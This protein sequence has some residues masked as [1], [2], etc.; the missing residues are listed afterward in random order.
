MFWT[1]KRGCVTQ[2]ARVGTNHTQ[3][4]SVSALPFPCLLSP[5]L[6]LT[7]R[8]GSP[9]LGEPCWDTTA[10]GTEYPPLVRQGP[11]EPC[12]WDARTLSVGTRP[13]LGRT[14]PLGH[15]DPGRGHPALDDVLSCPRHRPSSA[16][17]RDGWMTRIRVV[18]RVWSSE[19]LR[20][21]SGG[22][23]RM[24]RVV[25]NVA[26]VWATIRVRS[27][28]GD[29]FGVRVHSERHRW[30]LTNCQPSAPCSRPHRPPWVP[31]PW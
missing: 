10:L 19:G 29:G 5:P 16:P 3:S 31:G 7:G 11:G 8:L 9:G 20:V 12:R 6:V 25:R 13:G 30:W 18:F 4:V 15:Q 17:L 24:V 1:G 2:P 27:G 26:G 21:G 28:T 14:M 23:D 22:R